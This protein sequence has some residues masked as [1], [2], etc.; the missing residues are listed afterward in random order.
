MSTHTIWSYKFTFIL[1]IAFIEQQKELNVSNIGLKDMTRECVVEFLDWLQS[2]RKCSAGTRNVRLAALH[3]F[4]RFL[5]YQHP[6]NMN[7]WQ[8]ILSIKGKNQKRNY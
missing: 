5:Q 3:S 2:N 1:F 7:E 8:R 4:S 6:E